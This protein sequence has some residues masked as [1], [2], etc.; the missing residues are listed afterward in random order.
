M[1]QQPNPKMLSEIGKT[2]PLTESREFHVMKTFELFG[3]PET[4][5]VTVDK[6]PEAMK[7]LGQKLDDAELQS[8]LVRVDKDGDGK[9]DYNEF[10]NVLEERLKKVEQ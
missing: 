6:F 4:G 8:T 10:K 9:I 3:A 1:E 2:G 5:K 7:A